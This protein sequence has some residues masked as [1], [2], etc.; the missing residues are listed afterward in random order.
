[1]ARQIGTLRYPEL[2]IRRP[3]YNG[4]KVAAELAWGFNGMLRGELEISDGRVTLEEMRTDGYL[5][6]V[7]TT[8]LI[9]LAG[10]TGLA[11][12]NNEDEPRTYM[13]AVFELS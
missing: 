10:A 1:M 7:V 13:P 6:D 11:V 2:D 3:V 5:G 8:S 9:G 4:E 12:S